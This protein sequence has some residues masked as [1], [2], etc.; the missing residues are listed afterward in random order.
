[1]KDKVAL[2]TGAASGI[3]A[4]TAMAIAREGAAVMVCDMDQDKGRQTVERICAAGG[5]ARFF[6]LD[7]T[8]PDAHCDAVAE[9]QRVYGGLDIAVNCAGV[10]VGPSKVQRPIHE[11]EVRDWLHV[12]DVNLNGVFYGMRAQIP[13]MIERGGGSIVNVGSINCVVGR[14]RLSPYVSS[15]HAVLG[16]TRAAALDCAE[17]RIR[18][19]AVGPGYV[20]TPMQAGRDTETRKAYERLHPLNRFARA[21]EIA[22]AIL[23]LCS[24]KASFT[25]GTFHAVDGGY[26]AQ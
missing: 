6:R 25:T 12:L 19:N 8:Q 15:K 2:V 20:D 18:I 26:T 4:A 1:M 16:L 11:T 13:Q 7:V 3:G 5:R 9:I 22:E 14:V 21:D 24:D 23:W 10:S 17:H